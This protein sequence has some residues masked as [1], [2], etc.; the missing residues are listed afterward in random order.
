L[1]NSRVDNYFAFHRAERWAI[2]VRRDDLINQPPEY[3]N[4]N[5]FVCA[6]HFENSMFLNDLHNRLQPTAIPTLVDVPFP[7]PTVFS[8]RCKPTRKRTGGMSE[9]ESVPPKRRQLTYCSPMPSTSSESSVSASVSVPEIVNTTVEQS[10]S[11]EIAFDGKKGEY[12]HVMTQTSSIISCRTP[13][14]ERLR[15]SLKVVRVT[16]CRLKASRK[17]WKSKYIALKNERKTVGSQTI[18]KLLA[19]SAKLLTKEGQQFFAAQLH[20]ATKRARGR[21]YSNSMKSFAL[22]MFYKGPKAYKFL[23]SIFALP[24][25][26]SLDVWL[27]GMLVPP[28]LNEQVL[29]AL[30]FRVNE[31][32]TRDR[33]C[34]LL[35][36]EIS[37]KSNLCYDRQMDVVVGYEDLGGY[38]GR[39]KLIATN[40]L[41][42]MV[43]GLASNWKQPVGYIIT[44]SACK[45]A[46]LQNLLLDVIDKLHSIG[47][48]VAVVISDQGSNFLQL[49][50]LLGVS[51]ERPYFEHL[52]RKHFYMFDPPHL[53]KSIRNNLQNYTFTFDGS[54]TAQ[55]TDIEEFFKLDDQ[56][57]FKLAPKL[58]KKHIDLP[59]FTKMKVKFAAQVLS[60]T[61][62]AG[63]ETHAKLKGYSCSDTAEFLIAFDDLFDALN[64]SHRSCIKEFKCAMQAN[65]GHL[66]LFEQRLK[67]LANL[68]VTDKSGKNVTNI[69]KCIKG[70]QLTLS[71]ALH[72][73][74]ILQADY[75]FEFLLTR[76]LNQDPLEIFFSVIRQRGGNCENPTPLTFSRLFKQICCQTLL[77]PV[78]GANCEIDSDTLLESVTN[79]HH[80]NKPILLLNTH[81][82][83]PCQTPLLAMDCFNDSDLEGNGLFYVCGFLLRKLLKWHSCEMCRSLWVDQ[84]VSDNSTYTACRQYRPS[85]IK[86]GEGL[87]TVSEIFYSYIAQCE[88]MFSTFFESH[89]HEPGIL[90]LI[91]NDL[92]SYPSPVDCRQFP[93][94]L[95][96]RYFVRMR[97]YYNLKFA[98]QA[99]SKGK[100][101]TKGKPRKDRK[102]AKLQH[103]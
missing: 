52:N 56:Q 8:S 87:V 68:S 36:D 94:L 73:W 71:A 65:S 76:R 5:C 30:S 13:R 61:V 101:N 4:K 35:I 49:T 47:L 66:L 90:Q 46:K 25:K 23:S 14:K 86:D 92:M 103:F 42:F 58:T 29:H 82:S 17:S 33:V 74:P 93:K 77:N 100:Q 72:M 81:A 41:V 53:L 18:D 38:G 20:L 84:S 28:G 88:C 79:S 19:K 9:N 2:N 63:L 99:R 34:A 21:R 98:N 80:F 69:I 32:N 57:R 85:E 51:T 44:Q 15:R 62:A 96:L 6:E 7:P 12:T 11:A 27:Q 60:R 40:A 91:V 95:F 97:I 48:V 26:S 102:L 3:L 45:A 75:Q 31:L 50:R 39:T 78:V 54:K 10:I 22:S 1:Y 37:I 24:S 67:W 70:W 59:A 43:R 16:N 64:S 83:Q 89:S 55:W